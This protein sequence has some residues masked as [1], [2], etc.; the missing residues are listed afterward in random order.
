MATIMRKMNIISRC[1][2]LYRSEK[3]SE[4][5][6]GVYHSYILAIY[7]NPGFSQERLAKHLCI[8][9]SSVTR[10]LSYLEANGYVKRI[11]SEE[12]KREMLVYPTEKM[13]KLH[14]EVV[15]ITKKWNSL[16]ADGISEEELKIFHSILDKML[17]KSI[18][19]AYSGGGTD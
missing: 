15:K 13:L 7:K 4:H 3:L 2:A 18:E 12:D 17:D 10:H 11:P 19:I 1:E 6:P 8:N 9:K 14:P 16:L 5:L